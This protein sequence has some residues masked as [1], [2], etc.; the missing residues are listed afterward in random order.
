MAAGSSGRSW[1]PSRLEVRPQ[2]GAPL[3]V[4]RSACSAVLEVVVLDSVKRSM[5][6]STLRGTGGAQFRTLPGG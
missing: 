1:P 5:Q 4:F 2:H 6:N 3:R